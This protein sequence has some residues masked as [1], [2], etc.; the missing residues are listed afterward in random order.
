MRAFVI[1]GVLL[2]AVGVGSIWLINHRHHGAGET[3]WSLF[4]SREKGPESEIPG[5]SL[6]AVV[7]KPMDASTKVYGGQRKDVQETT[8]RV[9]SKEESARAAA[10]FDALIK[11]PNTAVLY[12]KSQQLFGESREGQGAARWITLGGIFSSSDSYGTVFISQLRM[13]TPTRE[14]F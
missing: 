5:A 14:R 1:S 2:V 6:K 11:S 3:G 8:K 10:Y 4:A 9:Y 13:P 12:R 7:K